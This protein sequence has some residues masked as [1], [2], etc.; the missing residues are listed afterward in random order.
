MTEKNAIPPGP[1][2]V[3]KGQAA[4]HYKAGAYVERRLLERDGFNIVA[5]LAAGCITAGGPTVTTQA[6]R[7]PVPDVPPPEEPAKEIPK[8]K[9]K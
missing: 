3:V 5:M 4:K 9:V 8:P 1:F 2:L 6:P 7:V